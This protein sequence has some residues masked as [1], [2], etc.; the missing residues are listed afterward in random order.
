[1]IVKFLYHSKNSVIA[2]IEIFGMHNNFRYDSENS[3]ITKFWHCS[4]LFHCSLLLLFPLHYSIS[5]FF[6]ILH[7]W[8]TE[9]DR[10]PYEIDGNQIEFVMIGLTWRFGFQFLQKLQK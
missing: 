9:I 7:F 10:I 6:D 3:S 4:A 5:F 2:K 1:M 8:L